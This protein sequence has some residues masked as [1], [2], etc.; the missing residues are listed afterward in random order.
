MVNRTVFI[1]S[2]PLNMSHYRD[3]NNTLDTQSIWSSLTHL[4]SIMHLGDVKANTLNV[5]KCRH[6]CFEHSSLIDFSLKSG[7]L[8]KKA[9]GFIHINKLGV[10]GICETS[11]QLR[12]VGEGELLCLTFKPLSRHTCIHKYSSGRFKAQRSM[13]GHTIEVT[14]HVNSGKRLLFCGF[15]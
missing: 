7:V 3:T 6:R 15:K 11:V 4:L 14:H 2:I 12:N 9:T 8:H 13:V 10:K 1:L 5:T